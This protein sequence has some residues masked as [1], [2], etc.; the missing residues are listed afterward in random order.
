MPQATTVLGCPPARP[1]KKFVREDLHVTHSSDIAGNHILPE[2]SSLQ[3][4][5][6][7]FRRRLAL[8]VDGRWLRRRRR[9]AAKYGSVRNRARWTDERA[10]LLSRTEKAG[11][12]RVGGAARALLA[13][14]LDARIRMRAW[15]HVLQGS[16]EGERRGSC[17][18]V[19]IDFEARYGG[20]WT[21]HALTRVRGMRPHAPMLQLPD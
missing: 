11:A 1:K 21:K 16:K 15:T 17:C 4:P 18:L 3:H 9:R 19:E 7:L 6:V 13:P 20:K 14:R 8:G 12:Q 10:I 2:A 5:R